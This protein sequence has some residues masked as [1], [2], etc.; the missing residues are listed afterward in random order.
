MPDFVGLYNNEFRF[1]VLLRSIT[2]SSRHQIADAVANGFSRLPA[3]VHIQFDRVARER[4]L[5]NL[6]QALNLN[7]V[8]LCAELAAWAA[9][10]SGASLLLRNFLLDSQL[11]LSDI[12]T[13]GTNAR[14]GTSLKRRVNLEPEP[15]G[16][17]E[18]VLVRRIFSV[19][20]AN[21]PTLLAAWKV[22]LSGGAIDTRRVQMLAYQ[23]LPTRTEVIAPDQFLS[24]VFANPVAHAELQEI[25]GILQERSALEPVPLPGAPAGWPLALHGRYPRAEILS[26]V[27]YLT[28]TARPLSDSVKGCQMPAPR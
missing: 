14:S 25:V 27:G 26:A 2:G 13:G 17:R 21:D 15:L 19:L 6:Q 24:L 7:V 12:Y 23:L 16:P 1:D 3:G 11:K 22:A 4:V 8:R 10:Q 18:A 9:L 5:T 28:P 20:H